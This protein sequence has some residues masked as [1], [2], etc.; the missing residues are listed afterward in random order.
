MLFSLCV[1]EAAHAWTAARLGDHTAEFEGRVTLNPAYHVDPIGSLLIPGLAIFGPLF[2]FKLFSGALIGWA[3]PTPIISRN[4]QKIRRD[5][6][7]VTLAGPASNLLLALLAMAVLASICLFISGGRDMVLSTF[8]NGL[9][10]GM[11]SNVQ[12]IIVLAKAAVLIN[13]S[14]MIF[15][16][17]PIPPLDGSYLLRNT[18]PYNAMQAYDRIPFWVGWILMIFVGGFIIDLLLGPMLAVI[19]TILSL[20]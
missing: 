5:E 10:T 4:F 8:A 9:A 19:Y 7:L 17:L 3:K 20:L 13:L 15:N 1:H 11:L 2:G 12:A 16:L 6:N 18:L 14:L